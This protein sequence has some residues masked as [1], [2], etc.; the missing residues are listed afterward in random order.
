MWRGCADHFVGADME[1]A[2]KVLDELRADMEDRYLY[3]LCEERR[4]ITREDTQ[5]PLRLIVVDELAV[6]TTA[7]GGTQGQEEHRRVLQQAPGSRLP[8]PGRGHHHDR[9]NAEAIE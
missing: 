7:A 3:L 5:F 9:R 1:Q 6:F 4:K 2:V 8:G